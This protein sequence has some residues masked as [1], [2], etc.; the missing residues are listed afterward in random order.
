[1]SMNLLEIPST[2]GIYQFLDANGEVLYVGKA[3]NL[4]NRVK[5]YFQKNVLSPKTKQLV[6]QIQTIKTIKTESEFDAL[7]LEAKLI[8]RI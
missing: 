7:L 4:K 2:A 8:N 1:M 3:I 6:K 5:S